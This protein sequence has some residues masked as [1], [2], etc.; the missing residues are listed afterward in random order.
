MRHPPG[1]ALPQARRLY[2]RLG[3]QQ[4]LLLWVVISAGLLAVALAARAR[5]SAAYLLW[6]P[7]APLMPAN[8]PH[9]RAFAATATTRW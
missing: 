9:R 6:L 3:Q 1:T 8:R 5:R 4:A 2:P 7:V